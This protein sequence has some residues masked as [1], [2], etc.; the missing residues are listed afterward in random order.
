MIKKSWKE[1]KSVFYLFTFYNEFEEKHSA[2][3]SITSCIISKFNCTS[4]KTIIK[5][6]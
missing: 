2:V 4:C 6:M 3:E 5:K 1:K